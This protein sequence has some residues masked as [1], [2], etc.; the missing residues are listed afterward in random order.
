VP[1]L[2]LVPRAAVPPGS[3]ALEFEAE[4][5]EFGLP[6]SLF[7]YRSETGSNL[8]AVA[9]YATQFGPRLVPWTYDGKRWRE[10]PWPSPRSLYGLEL[11][12]PLAEFKLLLAPDEANAAATRR[13]LNNPE[14]L[15]WYGGAAGVAHTDLTPLTGR[16]VVIWPAA[17]A[18]SF[19]AAALLA[20]RLIGITET[21][22]IV[23]T[24]GQSDGHDIC[25]LIQFGADA[26]ALARFAREHIVEPGK[27][28]GPIRKPAR[29]PQQDTEPLE[30]GD[31]GPDLDPSLDLSVGAAAAP[32][33][34]ALDL[35]EFHSEKHAWE[36]FELAMGAGGRPW[37]NLDNVVHVLERHPQTAGRFV[38]DEFGDRVLCDGEP[39]KADDASMLTLLLQRQIYLARVVTSTV[40]EAVETYAKRS[41][42]HPVRSYLDQLPPWDQTPRAAELLIRGFGA[43]PSPYTR[44]VGQ[45]TLVAAVARVLDPGCF[46][47]TMLVLEGA[48]DIGKSTGIRTLAHP[49][50]F[51]CTNRLDSKEFYQDIQ[52]R[53][54]IELSEISGLIKAGVEEVKACLSRR[55]D[56]YRASFGRRPGPHPRQ[57]I[58]IGSTNRSDWMSD[59]TG[60]SRFLPVTCSKV[61][62]PW[63]KQNRD[64]LWSEALALYRSIRSWEDYRPPIP[65]DALAEQIEERFS[66]DP[67]EESIAEHCRLRSLSPGYVLHRDIQEDVLKLTPKDQTQSASRRIVDI[68]KY[69]L[70]WHQKRMRIHGT[71]HR[72]YLPPKSCRTTSPTS[73][74]PEEACRTENQQLSEAVYTVDS[75]NSPFD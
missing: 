10:K 6:E 55:D 4:H 59:V 33:S 32:L 21:L 1:V 67:W 65:L 18:D 58:F 52:G 66:A 49:W 31:I 30:R 69:R 71:V 28:Q 5:G 43:A 24:H 56:V 62:L 38:F 22:E 51:D 42:I 45:Y 46:V 61:D 68:L 9:R 8:W 60:G 70:G 26:K 44:S 50:Y 41:R 37:G 36:H 39:W 13:I 15:S 12:A 74:A 7:W 3:A 72:V 29:P 75:R 34:Q 40:V 27:F 19:E 54:I 57:C 73:L 11:I 23:D 48:Q 20:E 25:T 63:L 17:T 14:A 64:Q 53:W 47:K 2:A 16:R 35:P